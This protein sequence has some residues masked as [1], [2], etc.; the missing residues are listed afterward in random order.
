[1]KGGC[2]SPD[3]ADTQAVVNAVAIL[4]QCQ[5]IEQQ[6]D[7]AADSSVALALEYGIVDN[8]E[9]LCFI[10]DKE[11]TKSLKA[12]SL[13]AA[14]VVML[15]ETLL[16]KLPA[17]IK[18][19]ISR[20]LDSNRRHSSN[21]LNQIISSLNIT[22]DLEH[23]RVRVFSD[24]LKSVISLKEDL[25]FKPDSYREER[26]IF[27]V[28]QCLKS[29]EN[30]QKLCHFDND[31]TEQLASIRSE[32]AEI[33]SA[34]SRIKYLSDLP[35]ISA[36]GFVR[37]T[38]HYQAPEV[39]RSERIRRGLDPDVCEVCVIGG[40]PGGISSSIFLGERGIDTVTFESGFFGQAFSDARAKMVHQ[41]RT[42][43]MLSSIVPAGL[44]PVDMEQKY[45][46][47][48]FRRKMDLKRRSDKALEEIEKRYGYD[49]EFDSQ[50]LRDPDDPTAPI[51]RN[52]LFAYLAYL[53]E[54]AAE[55]ESVSMIE[56]SPVTRIEKDP[57]S[58]L[59]IVET[60]QGHK[61]KAKKLVV[62][63]GFVGPEGEFARAIPVMDRLARE[64]PGQVLTIESEHD[65]TRKN[66]QLK[67][68]A[69]QVC[70]RATPETGTGQLV[71][72]HAVLGHSEIKQYIQALPAG[73]RLAVIGSG[74]SAAKSVLEI[75]ALN[76]NVRVDLFSS[77]KL[78]PYQ[79]QFPN[80]ALPGNPALR[81]L[82]D[83]EFAD[84]MREIT[85]KEFGSPIVADTMLTLLR[86]VEGGRVR[87]FE[88]GRHFSDENLDIRLKTDPETGQ[89][90][91]EVSLPEEAKEIR[92]S[93]KAQENEWAR[94]GL[95]SSG[96]ILPDDRLLSRINGPI[97]V[98]T[99]YDRKRLRTSHPL[100]KQLLD[101]GL[102]AID[103]KTGG[104][105]LDDRLGLAS[106]QDPNIFLVG[107]LE[108][109]S[110]FDTAIPG[111]SMRSLV[112]S[113]AIENRDETYEYIKSQR[114]I[115]RRLL[116]ERLDEVQK[117]NGLTESRPEFIPPEARFPRDGLLQSLSSNCGCS[118]DAATELLIKRADELQS[119]IRTA[120]KNGPLKKEPWYKRLV[121]RFNVR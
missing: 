66:S 91:T 99:G 38:I 7:A 1:M 110:V 6:I 28:Q 101:Q 13:I 61:I 82:V 42:D 113:R 46:M 70:G 55:L 63:C 57:E 76:P 86:E 71:V 106:S 108:P 95:I 12:Y 39:L 73:T 32:L 4:E 77:K 109:E 87:I 47:P 81:S 107:S 104:L 116:R 117:D 24:L 62:G 89:T 44:L 9:L 60:A 100:L 112:V 30:S 64:N 68:L 93:L 34:Q 103:P 18:N 41:M 20:L 58:G 17:E 83:R 48:A 78:E 36:D 8:P 105:D 11:Q 3:Q 79:Y 90:V 94:A 56:Q 72:S 45:G 15:A 40:G 65:L 121:R 14:E 35:R 67:E 102:V 120:L 88:L 115:L 22:E 10:R 85:R 19:S 118:S 69:E 37:S 98:A 84:K 43:Q 75:L 74:E 119:R 111:I 26:T 96:S 23:D 27:S 25:V 21:E 50:R 2:D 31:V 51:R 54:K 53:A 33:I 52:E 16:P 49:P 29:I 92:S 59:F 5:K 114:N 97:I 80:P